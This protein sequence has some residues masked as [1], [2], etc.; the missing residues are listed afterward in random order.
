[1]DALFFSNIVLD[2]VFYYPLFMA[3]LWIMGG[4]YY[5][6][7]WER[8]DEGS[9]DES[10][11]L[12]EYP[13][14]SILI[15]CYNEEDTVRDTVAWACAQRYPDY[16]VIAI[17]DG[18]PDRT[19]EILEE[20][21]SRFPRLRV[22]HHD[23]NQGK[24][25]GLRTG[26]MAARGEYLVCVDGDSL[27]APHST[28]WIMR[29]FVEGPRVGAVT[30]NPRIRNRSTLLGRLQVGEFSAIVGLIKR[31]QRIYGRVFT[32]SG[33]VTGIRRSALHR[34]DYWSTDMV[35]EDIDI[36]WALQRD[37]WDVRYEPNALCWILMPET[38]KGLWRQRL[39]WAQGGVEVL[40]KYGSSLLQWRKR[41]MWGVLLEHVTSIF[42][43][44]MMTLTILLWFL[45]L[46]FPMP[47]GLQVRTLL[48]EWYGVILGF[49][50]LLQFAVSLMIDGRYEKGVARHYYWMI[51][52]PIFFWLINMA[53]T[54][55]AFPK[56]LLKRRGTR[57]VWTSPDRGLRAEPAVE[58]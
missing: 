36:S 52:Y 34:V 23:S 51:W 47:E 7:H 13:F 42:W 35:T 14:V 4:V 8:R 30:G 21:R 1:M 22:I 49:T 32:V 29:H 37:H 19:G 41:R 6:W 28:S 45:G 50:C 20:L 27:L 10:P 58:A 43:A 40:L 5:Y 17:N 15:P 11:E 16:E 24:A 53:T 18:S 2:F 33:V 26:A 3:Y 48:P 56:A 54:V 57:A 55:V 31:T 25:M 9:P 46:A 44:Y 39:R 38:L 12:R